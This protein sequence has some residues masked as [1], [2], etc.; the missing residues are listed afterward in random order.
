MGREPPGPRPWPRPSP[1]RGRW[2]LTPRPP[3]SRRRCPPTTGAAPHARVV[4]GGSSI[5]WQLAREPF[6]PPTQPHPLTK[7]CSGE[8]GGVSLLFFPT[9][10][11]SLFISGEGGLL[12]NAF[13]R[14][15]DYVFAFPGIS[16]HGNTSLHFLAAAFP[17]H[18]NPKMTSYF[19][20]EF[21]KATGINLNLI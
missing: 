15:E 2:P 4:G 11:V 3:R 6:L 16:T 9:P 5:G 7:G 17:R 10:E 21:W 14:A 12:R 8:R 18:L 19:P 1:R 20:P 13:S